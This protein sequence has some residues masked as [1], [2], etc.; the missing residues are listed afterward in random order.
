MGILP[1]KEFYQGYINC[2]YKLTDLN[3]NIA[4]ADP[5]YLVNPRAGR[6]PIIWHIFCRKLHENEKK[7]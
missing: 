1:S 5:G 2:R 6:W 7:D 4:V 3:T